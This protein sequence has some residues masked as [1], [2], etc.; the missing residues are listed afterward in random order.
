MHKNQNIVQGLPLMLTKQ[1]VDALVLADQHDRQEDVAKRDM[2]G[3]TRTSLPF[4]IRIVT[5]SRDALSASSE[6]EIAAFAHATLRNRQVE[7]RKRVRQSHLTQGGPETQDPD[8]LVHDD[9]ASQHDAIVIDAT[10]SDVLVEQEPI[11]DVSITKDTDGKAT[12]MPCQGIPVGDP[13]DSMTFS[14][15]PCRNVGMEVVHMKTG[16]SASIL[17]DVLKQ[18][19]YVTSG[20]KFGASHLCYDADPLLFH[21]RYVLTEAQ[22]DTPWQALDLIAMARLAWSTGK[23]A[24]LAATKDGYSELDTCNVAHSGCIN[25]STAF[26]QVEYVPP[27]IPP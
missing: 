20:V 2:D 18:G 21:V 15:G 7:S 14:Y 17:H 1:Q 23:V 10:T 12:M 19:H 3:P 16:A 4:R 27:P 13:A 26:F 25:T 5:H 24:V 8:M 22:M 9:S 6:A 11:R